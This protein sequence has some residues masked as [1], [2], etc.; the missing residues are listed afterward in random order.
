MIMCGKPPT[1]TFIYSYVQI[2][3]IHSDVSLK[4]G[5]NFCNVCMFVIHIIAVTIYI[6]SV[7]YILQLFNY[8]NIMYFNNIDNTSLLQLAINVCFFV[9]C[10]PEHGRIR[11]KHVGGLPHFNI[12]LQAT[13]IILNIIKIIIIRPTCI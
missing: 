8:F 3:K 1:L 4:T 10:L 7:L 5:I 9:D 2:H 12:L 6:H 11:P 13:R